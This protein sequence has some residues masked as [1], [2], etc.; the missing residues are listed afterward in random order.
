M[1]KP[2]VGG[3]ANTLGDIVYRIFIGKHFLD[4][5]GTQFSSQY[6]F[7]NYLFLL[8]ASFLFAA[9]LIL[10]RTSP[11]LSFFILILSVIAV[12]SLFLLRLKIRLTIPGF[13][14]VIPF[15]AFCA[16]ITHL[17]VPNDIAAVWCLVFPI[18]SIFVLGIKYGIYLDIIMGSVLSTIIFTPEFSNFQ[19]DSSEAGIFF[20]VYITLTLVTIISRLIDR[21]REDQ[22]TNLNIELQQERD[23][24]TT[25]KDNLNVGIF[26]LDQSFII[27]PFYSQSLEDI[28]SHS[29]LTGMSIL[30]VFVDS[31][32][33]KQ[34][35]T[36][37]DYFSMMFNMTHN[38]KLLEEINPLNEVEYVSAETRARRILNCRFTCIQRQEE[39]LLLGAIYDVTEQ[40]KTER[41]LKEEGD[42]RQAEMK[43][44]FEIIQIDPA[45]FD[46]FIEDTDYQ[47]DRLN[48]ILKRKD[49]PITEVV[50]N[51]YQ[52]IH[53]IKSNAA[54][55]GLEGFAEKCHA[56]E[57]EIK[58]TQNK[59]EIK[60]EHLLHLTLEL[61]KIF[62]ER[63][64][65]EETLDRIT[66]F[67]KQS[68]TE[69][70][71][72]MS[73]RRAIDKVCEETGKQVVLNAENVDENIVKSDLRNILKEI[74]IQFARNAAFHGIED[75]DLRVALKKTPNG[76]ITLSIK[77]IGDM[78]E[79]VFADDGKGLNL[80]SIKEKAVNSN[81]IP[82]NA[83]KNQILSAMFIPGLSTSKTETMSAGRGIGLSLVAERLKEI[84]GKLSIS[85]K[86]GAGTTFTLHIPYSSGNTE[87]S[88]SSSED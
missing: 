84:N 22:V 34:R 87:E 72:I 42:K 23:E 68:S 26:L 43:A 67:R 5:K 7:M 44:L 36:L 25:M 20:F 62:V 17:A 38:M 30:D 88:D 78:I 14:F 85:T 6:L 59:P 28:L 8:S 11:Q 3:V 51:F 10:S 1:K 19:Y 79:I 18:V 15:G 39:S 57:D 12:I 76:T 21:E 66:S 71:F 86:E 16:Y 52:S 47:F 2:S 24:L 83:N 29:N 69:S 70:V 45:V 27:Q 55:L 63:D 46:E 80:N 56:L 53:A 75:P 9:A 54:I 74:V 65:L 81:L 33:A 35:N 49:L 41:Q 32:T 60:F 37:K 64:K 61:E 77:K 82:Y 31:I 4:Y 58:D 13:F 40:V 48:T 73:I 50:I